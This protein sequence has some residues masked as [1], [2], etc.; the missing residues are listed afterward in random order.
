MHYLMGDLQGCDDAFERLLAELGFSP[1]RD[2]LT[3][4]GDLVNRGPG[5]LPVLRRLLGLGNAV[6]AVLGNHDLHLLA[7]SVGARKPQPRDTLQAVLDAPD[8]DALLSWLRTRPLAVMQ[9]GWLCVHAGVVPAWSVSQTLALGDEVS[10]VLQGPLCGDFLHAM[11]SNN[12]ARWHDGLQGFD[13]LRHI[14]NVLTR[15]RFCQADGT[16]DLVTK[17]GA[18]AA[19][20]GYAPW[21]EVQG[22]ATSSVPVAF[23]H[24]STM[25]LVQRS[26]LLGLDTGCVWGGPLS[27]A[28]VDG[29]RCEVVQVPSSV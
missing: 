21:F 13:R 4:L 12:P 16:L 22:R 19:P 25:G 15:I 17:E 8:R 7:M 23:G 9:A 6:Q 24:W 5:S 2:R 1:S 27:A 10:N 20:A 3:L 14:V 29:D 26:H 28:R 11:Y 18:G